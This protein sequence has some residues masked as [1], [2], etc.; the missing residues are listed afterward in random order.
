MAT[1]VAAALAVEGKIKTDEAILAFKTL[2]IVHD[3]AAAAAA[4][5]E[6]RAAEA[7]PLQ[8]RYVRPRRQ[9]RRRRQLGA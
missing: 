5:V 1:E 6:V 8:L 9:R 2:A 7:P 4:I 3:S